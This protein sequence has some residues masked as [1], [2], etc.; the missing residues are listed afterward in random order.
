M[1]QGGKTVVLLATLDTKGEE[2]RFV[3]DTIEGRGLR[4]LV[5]DTGVRGAPAFA[6]DVSRAEVAEAAGED[7]IALAEARDRGRAAGVM[8]Q[9][10]A[11]VVTRLHAEG[12]LD[13]LLTIGGGTGSSIANPALVALPLGIPKMMVT[14][15]SAIDYRTVFA[16]KDVTVVYAVTDILGLN[17]VLRRILSNAA[18]AISGMVEQEYVEPLARPVVA[19]TSFGVTTPAAM[20]CR[21]ILLEHGFEVVV[22]PATGTGGMSLEELIDQGTVQAVLDLTTSELADELCG[23]SATAGPHRLEA[24]ARMGIPQVVIP[25]AMDFVNF[26]SVEQIPSQYKDRL[27][28]F[29][30]P[31]TALMRTT[32]EENIILGGQVGERVGRSAGP[33]VVLIP[34]RGYSDYDHEGRVFWDPAADRAF[35]EGVRSSIGDRIPVIEVDLH[36]NDPDFA[37][38]AVERLVHLMASARAAGVAMA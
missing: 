1:V 38:T 12:R 28:Y 31:T 23:G 26:R 6:A 9:G 5:V 14:V 19:V 11:V 10:A 18:G 3:K 32:A 22:F 13:G 15:R 16:R 24:A 2:T 7:V 8:G 21:E 29:H 34:M 35:V 30:T 4:T 20:R 37:A 33:A 25:G 27:F 36:V 17:P